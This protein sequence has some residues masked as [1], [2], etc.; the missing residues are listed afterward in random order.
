MERSYVV[1]CFI[2][3][4]QEQ[5]KMNYIGRISVMGIAFFG[6]FID[7]VPDELQRTRE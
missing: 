7:L 3:S 4:I 1:V 2:K 5:L 6:A